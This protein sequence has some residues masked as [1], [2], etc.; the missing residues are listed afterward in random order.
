MAL[1]N[2]ILKGLVDL[3][4]TYVFSYLKLTIL[5]DTIALL[6]KNGLE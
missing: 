2:Q 6:I 3:A 5:T 4:I 1:V